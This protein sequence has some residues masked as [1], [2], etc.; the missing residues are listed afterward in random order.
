MATI[1]VYNQKGEKTGTKTLKKEVFQV[2]V[3]Q[4]LMHRAL[5]RQLANQRIN[6]AYTKNRSEVRG[7][8]AKPYR[9]KGTGR[10]RQGTIR[11]PHMKGGG[12]AF[13]PLNIRNF[14]LNMPKK[15][16]RNALFSALTLKAKEKEVFALDSFS[17]EI[18]TKNFAEML[19]KLPVKRNALFL[20]PEKNEIIEKSARNL[21][22]VKTLLVNNL[23]LADLI[24]FKTL[25][26]VSD[27]DKKINEIF[28][29]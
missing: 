17:G 16:R 7:G 3:N 26:L 28:L 27:S 14:S 15:Q 25:V 19:K 24:K 23:N 20:L 10:A 22:D 29:K 18:K 5:L 4:D 1:D 6:L 2:T 9:Q 13:G 21:V 12:K 8:G 11:A